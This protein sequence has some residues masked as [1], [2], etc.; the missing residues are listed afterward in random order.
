V[1]LE[2]TMGHIR[3]SVAESGVRNTGSVLETKTRILDSTL[4]SIDCAE[5]AVFEVARR[6]GLR[7]TALE[8]IGLAVHEVVT[9]AMVHGNESN[10]QK[11]VVVTVS[12]TPDELRILISDQ[13][14]GFDPDCLLDPLSPQ[15]LLEGSGRGIYLART[16]MDEFCV[17]FD[18]AGGTTVTMVKYLNPTNAGR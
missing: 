7:D 15:G 8:H 5:S 6:G 14:N 13:G 1:I 12:R 17:E 18:D 16:F 3:L 11:R 10:A 9:N 2:K 4:E